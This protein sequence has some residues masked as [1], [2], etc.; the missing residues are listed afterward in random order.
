MRWWRRGN[1]MQAS[2]VFDFALRRLG[3]EL[4]P[5]C[6]HHDPGGKPAAPGAG[7]GRL[8]SHGGH[9]MTPAQLGYV[10]CTRC[11]CLRPLPE[12]HG[13]KCSNT[14]FCDREQLNKSKE[15]SSLS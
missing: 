8:G 9:T 1:D 15:H 4:A 12:L 7:A 2:A 14:D 10:A 6:V 5:R 13:T 3:K 11:G